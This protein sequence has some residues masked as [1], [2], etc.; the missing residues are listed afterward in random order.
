MTVEKFKLLT[1]PFSHIK[2]YK[3]KSVIKA[4]QKIPSVSAASIV[5][6]VSR[7]KFMTKLSKK[8]KN[9]GWETNYGYGTKKH[10]SALK[11]LGSTNYHR[12]TFAPLHKI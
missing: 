7:D 4:D 3:L 10:L 9:Y 8:F 6:K 5:A 1:H 12:K 11:K 2:D